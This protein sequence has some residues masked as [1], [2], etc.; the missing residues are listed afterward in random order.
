LRRLAPYSPAARISRATRLHPTLMLRR[1]GVDARRA[2]GGA[3]TAMDL[4]DPRA[5]L[6]IRPS[7]RRGRAL[8]PRVITAGGGAQ[9]AHMVS[10]GCMAWQSDAWP[11]N[12]MHGLVNPYECERPTARA[13]LLSE[14]GRVPVSRALRAAP[15]S[16]GAAG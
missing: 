12:R 4:H 15:L 11:G 8:A 3:R 1:L 10:I 13:G 9:H 2:V 7:S 16:R 14:P 5:Q 6:A